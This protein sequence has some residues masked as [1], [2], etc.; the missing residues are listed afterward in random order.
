MPED[1]AS[2]R[3]Q[4]PLR[5]RKLVVQTVETFHKG[6]EPSSV[7]MLDAVE[8]SYPLLVQSG[9]D[10]QYLTHKDGAGISVGSIRVLLRKLAIFLYC[11]FPIKRMLAPSNAFL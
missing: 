6:D 7:D 2:R 8:G 5:G 10:P 4:K 11:Y 9:K 3:T 1:R